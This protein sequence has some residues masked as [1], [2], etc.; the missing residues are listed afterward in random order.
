MKKNL[1]MYFGLPCCGAGA[2]LLALC[3][4]TTV[5]RA[6][7]I[8]N[9]TGGNSSY[10]GGVPLG[11]VFTMSGTGGNLTSLTLQLFSSAGGVAE[12]DLYNIASGAP[13][14]LVHDVEPLPQQEEV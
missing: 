12:V 2:V 1:G 10:T 8:V 4:F 11:Q 7:V 3:A 14:S 5:S 13:N 9:N 6:D